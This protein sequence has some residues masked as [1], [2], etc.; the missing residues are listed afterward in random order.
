MFR[1]IA[2]PEGRHEARFRFQPLRGLLT[3]MSSR[4]G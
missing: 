4:A 2:I 1:A 3:R